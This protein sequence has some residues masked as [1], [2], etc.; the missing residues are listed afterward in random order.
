[1]SEDRQDQQKGKVDD[2]H[3]ILARKYLVYRTVLDAVRM[4]WGP[5]TP[6]SSSLS[7]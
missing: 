7:E 3:M 6:F 1:M 5:C 4:V 2:V